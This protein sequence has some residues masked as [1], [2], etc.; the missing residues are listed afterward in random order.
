MDDYVPVLYGDDEWAEE[1]GVSLRRGGA[2][3]SEAGRLNGAGGGDRGRARCASR[4]LSLGVL[5]GFV[6]GFVLALR[7]ARRYFAW[8]G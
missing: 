1:W 7:N 5:V 8:R 6:L 3:G 2:G 4:G